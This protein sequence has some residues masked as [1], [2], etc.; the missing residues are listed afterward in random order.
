MSST[1]EELQKDLDELV[2]LI[3]QCKRQK[4]QSIIGNEIAKLKLQIDL[5]KRQ[6]PQ[7]LPKEE[8][9][10]I[11]TTKEE[12]I[13]TSDG[14]ITLTSYSFDQE[15]KNVKV[16]LFL[17]DIETIPKEN[18]TLD[19]QS[20][21]FDL[22]ILNYKG[23]NHRFAI[24]R[25]CNTIEPAGCKFLQKNGKIIITLKKEKSDHWDQL[26]YK[27]KPFNPDAKPEKNEDPNAAMMNM[28][29][30]LYEEGDDD[31]KR[32][33][34]QSWTKSQ[35]EKNKTGKV[36]DNSMPGFKVV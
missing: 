35:D 36:T 29:K 24:K 15:G 26:A 19:V 2:T 32:T 21:S 8:T 30:K 6:A 25:L 20:Q 11:K 4:V 9:K 17:Q 1:A 23:K 28:M 12:A 18:I 3:T 27:E 33:I 34:A 7:A 22:K 5:E 31:M 13:T 10:E 16:Y 14:F